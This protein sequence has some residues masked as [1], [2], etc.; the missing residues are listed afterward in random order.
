[1]TKSEAINELIE[2]IKWHDARKHGKSWERVKDAARELQAI[3][4]STKHKSNYIN[5]T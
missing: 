5:P 1:M 4:T 3:V 2:A